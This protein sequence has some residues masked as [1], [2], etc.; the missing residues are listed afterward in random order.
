MTHSRVF[1]DG[2]AGT[3]GLQIRER[4]AGRAISSCSRSIRPK[5]KDPTRGRAAERRR[6]GDPLPAGRRGP[7]GGQPDQNQ[8]G[9]GHR[10]LDR[11]R[12]ATAGPMA[13][14]RWTSPAPAIRASKR[15]SNPGCYPTGFIALIRPLVQ[16]GLMPADWPVTRQRGLR[17]FRRRQG[18]D[19][20]VRGRGEPDL[21]QGRR[22][23]STPWAWSTSMCP[24]CR[25]AHGPAHPPLFAPAV[26]RYA[27][28]MLVEVPLHLWAL[29]GW[30]SS[31]TSARAPRALRCRT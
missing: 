22:T 24:R 20:R 13:S 14:P 19:R 3:T 29:P 11:H 9:A 10:R 18:D 31:T 30:P 25:S 12:T 27:Q 1:I 7:R 5:R 17:L 15:V 23:A 28:G 26:G 4:L 16:A 6:R 2:E 8:H 21:H